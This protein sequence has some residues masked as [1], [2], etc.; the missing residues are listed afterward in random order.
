MPT[1]TFES[2]GVRVPAWLWG[3]AELGIVWNA[4]GLYQFVGN[5]TPAGQAAMTARMTGAQAA[6]YLSLPAWISAAFAAGVFG[7]L[8]GSVL[9]A[10]RRG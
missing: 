9:L 6:L 3:A 5:L 2:A 7:A 8:A 1:L 10:L 4:Y